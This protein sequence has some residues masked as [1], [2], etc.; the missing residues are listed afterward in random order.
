[1]P[2]ILFEIK[3]SIAFITLNRPEKFNAFNREMAL[4][5]QQRLDECNDDKNIRC[6]YITG[7]GKAF[8]A[9]QDL[10]EAV[11]PNSSA[12]KTMVSEHYNP[13]ISKIRNLKKPVMAAVN[14]VA[15]GAGANIALSC[16][17]VVAAESASFI[18][19]FSKIGL[20]PDSGG[21]FFLPRLIGFQKASALMML[22]EKVD[23]KEAE[24]IG[25]IYKFFPDN[26]FNDEAKKIAAALTELPTNALA[27]TKM[28]LNLSTMQNLQQ[29]LQTED[30]LQQ[31]AVLTSDFKEGLASFLQKRKPIFN[32][33]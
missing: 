32:R 19:A 1:M 29:Q 26:L 33:E 12:M 2:A 16:D 8:S 22:G 31:K 3:N 7:S 27:Y 25:M 6:V 10:G 18:Q 23:A 13:I 30:D 14:G 20:I 21:T 9:G 24:R 28:A 15:A 5:L 11:D 17:I 4:S